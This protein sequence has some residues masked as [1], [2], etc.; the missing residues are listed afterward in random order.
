MMSMARDDTQQPLDTAEDQVDAGFRRFYDE[1]RQALLT[2]GDAADPL[3]VEQAAQQVSKA[4][5]T[6]S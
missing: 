1:V 2:A 4:C 3:A 6:S 5:L